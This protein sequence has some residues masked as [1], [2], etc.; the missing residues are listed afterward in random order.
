MNIYSGLSRRKVHLCALQ[1]AA[2]IWSSVINTEHVAK[3]HEE[4]AVNERGIQQ[5]HINYRSCLMSIRPPRYAA[6]HLETWISF[7]GGAICTRRHHMHSGTVVILLCYLTHSG[8]VVIPLC[9]LT[10]L[11][12]A[13]RDCSHPTLLS[14]AQRDCSRPTLLSYAQRDCSRP[15]L[16]SHCYFTHS[17]IVAIPFCYLTHSG[18]VGI[19]LLSYV[20]QKKHVGEFNFKK[21]KYKNIY[22][23]L[24][25]PYKCLIPF[26]TGSFLRSLVSL[27]KYSISLSE[28][29]I[30]GN[31]CHILMEFAEHGGNKKLL[32]LQHWTGQQLFS[33][34]SGS[35]PGVHGWCQTAET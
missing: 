25:V 20:Q 34:A 24:N 32:P 1:V 26:H 16:L 14:Y 19:P 18:N 22:L 33:L 12:Y 31:A 30:S 3:H 23:R 28:T 21:F 17:G 7:S 13:Q 10:L 15:T 4:R 9:Y 8:T 35:W 2:W 6:E 29:V 27:F 11:S 5:R